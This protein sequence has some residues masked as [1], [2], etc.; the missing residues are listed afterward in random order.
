MNPASTAGQAETLTFSGRVLV[1]EGHCA[2]KAA[3]HGRWRWQNEG[4]KEVLVCLLGAGDP[5]PSDLL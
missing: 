5:S 1:A 3:W 2:L 4:V